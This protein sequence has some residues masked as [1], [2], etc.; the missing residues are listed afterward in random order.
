MMSPWQSVPLGDVIVHRKEFITIDDL[1]TYRRP[2]VQLHAEGIVLRDE[3][4]GALIKTKK[5]QLVRAGDFL[6]AE[7]DAKVGG[8][9]IVPS[10]LHGVIVSSHYFLFESRPEYLDERFLGWFI[11]TYAFRKQVEAQGSTNYAAI[12]PADVLRYQVPLPP[13]D[14]QRRIVFE[15]ENLAGKVTEAQNLRSHTSEELTA[16]W[17]SILNTAFRGHLV[18]QDPADGDARVIL[19]TLPTR[20]AGF[21]ETKANNAHPHQPMLVTDGLYQLPKM[22]AWTTLGS[23]LTHLIDCVNDTPEFA[24]RDTGFLGLKSTNVRPYH[25]DLRQKWFVSE[26]DFHRWNRREAPDDGDII[27]TREAPVGYACRIPKGTIACLTQRLM[28]LRPDDKALLPHL[29]L[30]YLNSRV[31][32]D[33]VLEHSRGLTTPHIRVQDA[34]NFLLPL[35]PLAQQR[36][37]VDALESL[38]AKAEAVKHL[39]VDTAAELDAM[40]PAILDKAFRGELSGRSGSP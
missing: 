4:P 5:Q 24:D 2:R 21:A 31:F 36:R 39:H 8:F 3:L 22:W 28:L 6:V 35:P 10:F 38:H 26:G 25:L 13:L 29:L 11:K 7:I 34:P 12:R 30:H 37:I 33:Q 40:I 23:V 14:E 19:N 20:H 32:L 27:L 1:K 18:E 15:I 9:G 17:P 16:L